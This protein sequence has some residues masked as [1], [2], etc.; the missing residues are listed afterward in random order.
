MCVG[1]GLLRLVTEFYMCSCTW[2]YALVFLC[3][4][5][6]VLV[7]VFISVCEHMGTFMPC[8]CLCVFVSEFVCL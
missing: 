3:K 6:H 2:L 1:L 7:S 8:M 4:C 5:R